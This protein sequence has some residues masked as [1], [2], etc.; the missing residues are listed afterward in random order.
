MRLHRHIAGAHVRGQDDGDRRCQP[1]SLAATFER[2]ADGV[3]VRHVACQGLAD[4]GL[5]LGGAVSFEQPQQRRGDGAEIAAPFGGADQ[6]ELASGSCLHQPVSS[7]V[8]TCGALF[9]DEPFDMGG[10]FDLRAFVVT[11]LMQGENLL[12][13]GDADLVRIGEYRRR[14]PHMGVRDGIIVQIEPDVR[15]LAGVTVTCSSNG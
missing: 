14:P 13:V 5:Q 9:S 4:C 1:A 8:L 2:Q 10:V 3:R 11:A 7:A 6:Q 15:Y 12:A